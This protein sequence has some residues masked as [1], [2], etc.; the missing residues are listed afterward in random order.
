VTCVGLP[1]ARCA[2]KCAASPGIGAGS[3]GTA[4]PDRPAALQANPLRRQAA[5]PQPKR[6]PWPPST[7][8]QETQCRIDSSHLR[9]GSTGFPGPAAAAQD[10]EEAGSVDG[11]ELDAEPD[12]RSGAIAE[13]TEPPDEGKRVF[14]G[15]FGLDRACLPATGDSGIV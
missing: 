15:R 6:H 5:A 7:G 9:F 12:S 4:G 8:G 13:A 3:S 10:S 14:Q 2:S 1:V 11:V